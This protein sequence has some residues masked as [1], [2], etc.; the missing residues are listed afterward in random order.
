MHFSKSLIKQDTKTEGWE[1][2]GCCTPDVTQRQLPQLESV[3]L[4]LWAQPKATVQFLLPTQALKGLCCS[5]RSHLLKTRK[6]NI[7][8]S[9]ETLPLCTK[10]QMLASPQVTACKIQ[11]D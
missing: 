1:R 4:T 7:D 6:Q 11:H 8:T 3:L 10:G 9:S 5:L 2:S